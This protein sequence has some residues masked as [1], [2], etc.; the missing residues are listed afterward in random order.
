MSPLPPRET[1]EAEAE[2]RRRWAE[3]SLPPPSGVLGPPD[4]PLV[5]QLLG[6]FAPGD[7][8]LQVALRSIRADVEARYLLLRGRRVVGSLRPIGDPAAIAPG[9]ADLLAA[10]GVWTGGAQ[11]HPWDAADRSTGVQALLERLARRGVVVLRDGPV[12]LCPGCASPRSPERT[13][14][15]EEVGDTYLVR[16]PLP[17]ADGAVDAVAWVDAP[18][19]L[20]ATS[21]LLVNPELGYVVADYRRDGS[22]ARLLLSRSSVDRLS[23]WLAGAEFSIVRELRGRELVGRRYLYPLRH[24]FPEGATLEPPAG[25]VQAVRDVG[26]IGTGIIPLVPGHGGPDSQI[27]ERLGIAGW[28]LLNPHGGFELA[29]QHKYAGLDLATANEF[30]A[31]DLTEGGSVLARLRVLRGV[32]HCGVCGRT[33]VWVP[34][35]AWRIDLARLPT[36]LTDRYARLLPGEPP[37][38]QLE[39]TPWP[40]SETVSASG[41]GS[42]VLLECGRC[43]RL[44]V[45]GAGETCR[46]GGLR[47]PVRRRLLPSFEGALAAWAGRDPDHPEALV[48][49]YLGD[50]RRSPSLVHHLVAMAALGE[51]VGEV[52]LTVVPTVGP[53]DLAELVRERGADALRAAIVGSGPREPSGPA[54][55]ERARQEQRRLARLVAL[56]REVA[57]ESDEALRRAVAER[58][59][60]LG[61]R[62]E[63]EDRAVLARW[64]RAARDAIALYEGYRPGEAYRAVTR[65]LDQDLESYRALVR[66]RRAGPLGA[67]GR[68]AVLAT[69]GELL[70][71]VSPLLAPVAPFTAEALY[72]IF[73]P[74]ASTIFEEEPLSPEGPAVDEELVLRWEEWEALLRATARLRRDLQLPAEAEIPFAAVV[75]EDEGVGERLRADH[76][77]LERLARLRRL[78]VASPRAPWPGRRRRVVPDEAEI[79]KAYPTIAPQVLH[80]LKQLPVRGPEDGDPLRGISVVVGGLTHTVPSSMLR[81]AEELPVGVVRTPCSL[82]ELFVELP[83]DG[84]HRSVPGAGL[85]TDARWLVRRVARRLRDDSSREPPA[86]DGPVAAVHAPEPLATELHAR[87]DEIVALL[88][89]RELSVATGE[90]PERVPNRVVGRTRTGAR[91]SVDL[92]ETPVHSRAEKARRRG[93]RAPRVPPP[94]LPLLSG[95]EEIDFTDEAVIA[96]EDEIRSLAERLTQRLERPVLGPSKVANAWEAG[97]RS[98]DQVETAEFERLAG[99]PGFGRPV[100]AEIFRR[101]GRAVPRPDAH[102]VPREPPEGVAPARDA[103]APGPLYGSSPGPSAS[104]ARPGPAVPREPLA[105]EPATPAG[106]PE[107][108]AVATDGTDGLHPPKRSLTPS[109]RSMELDT[110]SS[111]LEA[112]GPFLDA[113]AAGHRGLA[114]VREA[115]ERVRAH[116]GP[117]PVTVLW[118]TNLRRELSVHPSDLSAVTHRVLAAIRDEQVSAVFLEGIEYLAQIHGVP[119]VAEFLREIDRAARAS[120]TRLWV[121]IDPHLLTPTERERLLRGLEGPLET[122]AAPR[123]ARA[124]SGGS[125]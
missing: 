7:P 77:L 13:I 40:V 11:G 34:G 83:G 95:P 74:E 56:G 27:A 19:R 1:S 37:L 8:A 66:E 76:L 98:V 35:Q 60:D 53:V 87:S 47:V 6:G 21:A 16:F 70:L 25:T 114:V 49:L 33:L 24:E 17:G 68:R 101:A 82:G 110:S 81:L 69:L 55:E 3:R 26:D 64:A 96:R 109:H 106:S 75:V 125:A 12:R 123:A 65:F 36:E 86:S 102:R 105:R 46:C 113:T 15:Q 42:F 91:W 29:L 84:P 100:A 117:R 119:A 20:L 108:E 104:L 54:L 45:P 28:P 39:V 57:A 116:V 118:L 71:S 92:P 51:T 88:G 99:L 41:E 5:R 18:W 31:R 112:L 73:R 50:R 115:P 94:P 120:E 80:L 43:D 67:P 58:V 44:D 111:L 2:G 62:P 4:G 23:T 48:R 85:S 63:I 30:V 107:G 59:A 93:G 38:A 22:K 122:D 72:R 61:A 32:P 52:G 97:L 10:L 79:T 14:Y 89:L 124:E 103:V 90:P 121:H 9:F 78:E